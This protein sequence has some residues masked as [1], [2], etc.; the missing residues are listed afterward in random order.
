MTEEIRTPQ[1]MRKA[2]HELATTGYFRDLD[3]GAA[4]TAI[5]RNVLM[6]GRHEGLSGED[7]YTHLS[8]QLF[9][10]AKRQFQLL[11][12]AVNNQHP[13]RIVVTSTAGLPIATAPKDRAILLLVPELGGLQPVWSKGW[14]R[15]AWSHS[16]ETWGLHLPWG[17]DGKAMV[18]TLEPELHPTAWQ[19]LP[20]VE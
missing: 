16:R 5:V 1:Q 12:D 3:N 10:L 14:W 20:N 13:P 2:L 9:S 7:T 17:Q 15:G 4:V 6:F 8:W 11:L 19:E 18:G